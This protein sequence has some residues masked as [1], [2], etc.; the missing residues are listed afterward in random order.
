[1]QDAE[2]SSL[3]INIFRN[4]LL[5]TIDGENELLSVKQNDLKNESTGLTLKSEP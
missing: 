2:F 1:M 4:E 3:A 5:V